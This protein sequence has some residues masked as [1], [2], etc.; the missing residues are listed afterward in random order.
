MISTLTR[1]NLHRNWDQSGQH[2]RARAHPGGH[3]VRRIP[4]PEAIQLLGVDG[5]HLEDIPLEAVHDQ[6]IGNLNGSCN[7]ARSTV[8]TIE[9]LVPLLGIPSPECAIEFLPITVP[10]EFTMHTWYDSVPESMLQKMMD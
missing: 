2:R 3:W 10:T 9:D 1:S 6:T 4:I 7:L 5:R 8:C